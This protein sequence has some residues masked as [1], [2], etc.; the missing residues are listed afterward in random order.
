MIGTKRVVSRPSTWRMVLALA[1]VLAS[2]GAHAQNC[3]N[4]STGFVPL[5]DLG[6][7]L[8]LSRF[9]GGLYPNGSSV[10]PQGHALAGLAAASDIVPRDVGGSP[11]GRNGKIVLLSVGM[12][13]ASLDFCCTPESFA[14]QAAIHPSVN[15]HT[16]AIIN[17][18]QGGSDASAWIHSS[19]PAYDAIAALLDNQ[20]LSEAQVQAV[21]VKVADA[22]P[23]ISLPSS[24]ADAY[25]LLRHLADIARALRERYSSLKQVFYSSR[26]YGGYA[27]TGLNPEP[28]AY[29]SGFAVKWLVEAQID[30]MAGPGTPVNPLAGDLNYRTVAP[31]VAWGA[32]LWADGTT[33]RSDGL[34][35]EC[36]DLAS[37]GTH[38]SRGAV[39]KVGGLLLD[40]FLNSPATPWFRAN[41]PSGSTPIPIMTP[42]PTPTTT[43]SRMATSTPA[44]RCRLTGSVVGTARAGADG[45]GTALGVSVGPAGVPA[46]ST[47]LVGFTMNETAGAVRCADSAGNVYTV[48]SDLNNGS[49]LRAVVCVAYNAAALVAGN[50]VTVTHPSTLARSMSVVTVSGV[51]ASPLDR[52]AVSSGTSS[53]PSSGL[54]AITT[55]TNELIYGVVSHRGLR[56]NFTPGDG[57]NIVSAIDDG[58]RATEVG[59]RI[60]SAAGQYA[61]NGTLNPSSS[62]AATVLTLKCR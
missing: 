20:G 42:A 8:Y 24:A 14:G 44:A 55:Q 4:E 36:H 16:L 6:A 31:W 47:I 18:A 51:L 58:Q 25:T 29:E 56:T 39:R 21:W 26:I 9:Q 28:Y 10:L 35:Y 53:T 11:D 61:A 27:T 46:G 17:G 5:S 60:V 52:K 34:T 59:Y 33:P 2:S 43:P 7:G 41:S 32:Y 15:H 19:A 12:S 57:L 45:S 49:D 48:E 54:T 22:R 40:Y 13:N 1:L 37:D 62:W 38:P 30:Q 23:R 3:R 50:T